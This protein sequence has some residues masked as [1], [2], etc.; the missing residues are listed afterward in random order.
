MSPGKNA[1]SVNQAKF[2]NLTIED[3]RQRLCPDPSLPCGVIR[4]PGVNLP[5]EMK[6][7][8]AAVLIP[9]LR[10]NGV[11]NLL[12]TA[13]TDLVQDH[14]NQVSFPGGAVEPEDRNRA[15]TALRE[16]W[17]EIGM[18]NQEVT[19]LGYLPDFPTVSGFLITPVVGLIP[20]PYNF[21]LSLK[22]V[23]RV[24]TIPLDWVA[25]P[26]NYEERDFTSSI[27]IR[28]T[29]LFYREY[30]GEILWGISA[31]IALELAKTLD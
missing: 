19:V 7:R 21:K 12:L 13:R 1:S 5:A 11:W 6:Y 2:A 26:A 25:D 29:A 16:T 17:E 8:D 9:L 30:D 24:F 31:R 10:K 22:E 15:D 23:K 18:P 28:R 4:E 27:N 20:W 14:K 3:I